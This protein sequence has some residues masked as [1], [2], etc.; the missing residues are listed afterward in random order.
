MIIFGSIL[1]LGTSHIHN[2]WISL[3]T[4][5]FFKTIS[6]HHFG[7]WI[8]SNN[9]YHFSGSTILKLFQVMADEEKKCIML[10]SSSTRKHPYFEILNSNDQ[11]IK[12]LYHIIGNLMLCKFV[13]LILSL[14]SLRQ[15]WLPYLSHGLIC[16]KDCRLWSIPA[17]SQNL[18]MK[19]CPPV[20]SRA[21]DGSN[22]NADT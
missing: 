19:S 6:V 2:V 17:K 7:S 9:E 5:Q 20:T 21:P 3:C 4:L 11:I 18:T 8:G 12:H 1:Y 10:I 22:A 15:I 13:W 14:S 16:L